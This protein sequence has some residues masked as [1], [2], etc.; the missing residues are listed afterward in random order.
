MEDERILVVNAQGS[1]IGGCF[2]ESSYRTLHVIKDVHSAEKSFI[3]TVNSLLFLFLPSKVILSSR[4]NE[5]VHELVL[6]EAREMR[7][8]VEIVGSKVFNSDLCEVIIVDLMNNCNESSYTL[9]YGINH[10]K[11]MFLAVYHTCTIM[12]NTF[13]LT[14]SENQF[15]SVKVSSRKFRR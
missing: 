8:T 6:S 5:D 1:R 12:L 9:L 7:F 13:I 10:D 4:I 11:D 2:L 3:E 14:I 15:A